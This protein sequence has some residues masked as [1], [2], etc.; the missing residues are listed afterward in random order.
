M[1]ND[2][3]WLKINIYKHIKNKVKTVKHIKFNKM[4]ISIIIK[5]KKYIILIKTFSLK[6]QLIIIK[7]T[8]IQTSSSRKNLSL[9][10]T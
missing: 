9:E 1:R 3:Y 2:K 5:R 7:S 8:K 4:N 10:M 6:R